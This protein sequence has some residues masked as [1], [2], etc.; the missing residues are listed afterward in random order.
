[1][2]LKAEN[3]SLKYYLGIAVESDPCKYLSAVFILIM[4]GED[5]PSN[6]SIGIYHV[7]SCAR[8][9]WFTSSMYE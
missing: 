4:R 9:A 2:S 3:K 5:E 6:Y 1:M 8:R 7:F